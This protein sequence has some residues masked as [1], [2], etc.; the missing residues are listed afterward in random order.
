MRKPRKSEKNSVFINCPFDEKY[1]PLFEVIRFTLKVN[2]YHPVSAKDVND[3]AETRFSKIIK[4]IKECR[5]SIHDISRT[6]LDIDNNLPRFNMPFELG[7]ALG[8]KY[9]SEKSLDRCL[10]MDIEQYRYQKFLSDIAG[11]DINAHENNEYKVIEIVREW[12]TSITKSQIQS[13]DLIINQF[14]QF[15]TE[16][17]KSCKNEKI[18]PEKYNYHDF[19]NLIEIFHQDYQ[20][21]LINSIFKN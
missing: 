10:I 17:N 1:K 15:K 14:K 7:L 4:F 8:K 2:G 6:D 16:F 18:D 5:Y 9:F 11:N 19:N 13:S 3:S 12:L 20:S 21:S